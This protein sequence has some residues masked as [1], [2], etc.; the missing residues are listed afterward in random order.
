ME[1]SKIN[2]NYD[3]HYSTNMVRSTRTSM[4]LAN[5]MEWGPR[6]GMPEHDQSNTENIIS[7]GTANVGG[8]ERK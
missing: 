5:T 6:G 4:A 2:S 7:R 1:Q 8:K 3:K